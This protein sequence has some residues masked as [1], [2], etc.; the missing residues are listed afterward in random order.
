MKRT[1]AIALIAVAAIALAQDVP[2]TEGFDSRNEGSLHDQGN[3]TARRQNN[4]Q[5]QTSVVFAGTKAGTVAA[6]T[7]V[8]HV[9]TNSS[10][11][12]VWIDFY[13]RVPHADDNDDPAL[14]GS[15]AAAF[16]VGTDGKVRAISNSTWVVL[17]HVVPADTWQRFSV[18]L[19]YGTELW[20][21]YVA[22]STPGELS[23]KVATDLAFSASNTNTYFKGFKIRN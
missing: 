21:L 9:F 5:V 23:T 19:D 14:T 8:G 4:A 18:H 1:I 6:N 11:T 17:N 20:D 13:A 3:W 2:F 7:L 10:A 12:D 15:S 22:G 16:F